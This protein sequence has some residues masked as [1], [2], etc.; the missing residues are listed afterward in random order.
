MTGAVWSTP[1]ILGSMLIFVDDSSTTWKI[2]KGIRSVPHRIMHRIQDWT[3]GS[4]WIVKAFG[5]RS[6]HSRDVLCKLIAKVLRVKPRL[7]F[8]LDGIIHHPSNQWEGSSSDQPCHQA[9]HRPVLQD[10]WSVSLPTIEQ[11]DGPVRSSCLI[12][13]A[14]ACRIVSIRSFASPA[15]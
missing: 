12:E 15:G 4:V 2:P 8:M 6:F 13:V 1:E 9:N 3:S 10:S 5:G 7:P 11:F 14:L